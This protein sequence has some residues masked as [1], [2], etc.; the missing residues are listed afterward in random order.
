VNAVSRGWSNYYRYAHNISTISTKLTS[1]IFWRTIHYLGKKRCRSVT[2]LMRRRSRRHPKTGCKALFTYKP[3]T[4]P[5]P[6]NRY[7]LWHKTA[8]RLSIASRTAWYVQDKQAVI[9]TNWA[10]GHSQHKRLKIR[11]KTNHQCQSGAIVNDLIY[12][13]GKPDAGL[14]RPT[15]LE[16][17]G[18][19]RVSEM[20]L[21]AVLPPY[22][23]MKKR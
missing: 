6:E 9:D 5:T 20:R 23:S 21:R 15:G 7:Y 8:R 17:A 18:R 11:E 2:V 14:T 4:S 13:A 12:Y 22:T 1:I 10:K 16:A 3:G 19:I